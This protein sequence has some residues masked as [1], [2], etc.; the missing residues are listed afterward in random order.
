MDLT[1]FALLKKIEKQIKEGNFAGTDGVGI[2]KIEQTTTSTADDGN[3]VITV[4]LTNGTTSTF[5]VQNGSKG[6]KGD[7]GA[8]GSAGKDGTNGTSV[9]VSKVSESTAD[10]GSNV[11]TFSDGKTVTIK[12]GSKGSAGSN[13][14]DGTNGTNGKDGLSITAINLVQDATGVIT[15]GTATLSDNSVIDITIT[16]AE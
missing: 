15:S 6:S 3:N 16:T 7:T 9:T 1:S 8:T 2:S 4:T 10:G 14:K 12:N 11:V 5:K 13:G